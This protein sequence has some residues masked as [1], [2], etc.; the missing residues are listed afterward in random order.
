MAGAIPSKGGTSVLSVGLRLAVGIALVTVVLQGW[1]YSYRSVQAEYIGTDAARLSE[2]PG[3]ESV[4]LAQ[5]RSALRIMPENPENMTR[6]AVI[7]L[8]M[9]HNKAK[10]GSFRA[11]SQATLDEAL[12]TL[13]KTR[14]STVSPSNVERKLAEVNAMLS[15]VMDSVGRK[16]DSAAYAEKA[17][18]HSQEFLGLM[19]KPETDA[20]LFYTSAV[21][22]AYQADRH[23]LV[24]FF[25]DHCRQNFPKTAANFGPDL[26]LVN[27]SRLVIGESPV[28]MASVMGQL[29]ERPRD[30][31]LIGD[32]VLAGLSY[33]RARE[34]VL[35]LEDLD[36]RAPLPA[37][38]QTY[39]EQLR[40]I[41][42]PK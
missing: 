15:G 38:V 41:S 42:A 24:L 35:V 12:G 13:E 18:F 36:R 39:L 2:K 10:V 8:Q 7:Q 14:Y 40:R 9:E 4:A 3:M 6:H 16:E 31:R 32:L 5:L 34:A 28:M 26:Q 29:R 23:D 11:M 19:G 22:R 17:A 33:G 21:R 27:R 1:R 37:E 25:Y 20:L 30:P